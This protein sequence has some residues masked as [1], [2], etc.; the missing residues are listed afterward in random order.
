MQLIFGTW[1]DVVADM[2]EPEDLGDVTVF[3]LV[4]RGT[5]AGSDVPLEWAVWQVAKWRD[6]KVCRWASFNTREE[7]LADARAS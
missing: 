3:R 1:P 2:E 6:G 4:M 7:A 5:G